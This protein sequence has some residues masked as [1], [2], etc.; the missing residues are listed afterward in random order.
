VCTSVKVI[1]VTVKTNHIYRCVTVTM[2]YIRSK[3]AMFS[4]KNSIS[5]A[6]RS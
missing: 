5:K 1:F 2:D 3:R 4:Q 6:E